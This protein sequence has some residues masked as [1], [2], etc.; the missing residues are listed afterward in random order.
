MTSVANDPD[1]SV[2]QQRA[3]VTDTVAKTSHDPVSSGKSGS[4][5]ETVASDCYNTEA[6][7]ELLTAALDDQELTALCFD[8]FPDVYDKFGDGFGRAIKV[9][10]LLDYCR[11][12]LTFDKLLRI[13]QRKNPRQY[14]RFARR[15]SQPPLDP[16][17]DTTP[18][19]YRR[20][21]IGLD[22]SLAELTPEE[23]EDVKEAIIGAMA[24][25]LRIP[26]HHIHVLGLRNGSIVVNALLPQA[27][28][29]QLEQMATH[30]QLS[31][32]D[33]GL[34]WVKPH[35]TDLRGINLRGAV[36]TAAILSE[37]DL[38]GADLR[39]AVLRDA[40]LSRTNLSDAKLYGAILE[41]AVLSE[42][43]L[44]NADL[45]GAILRD[46]ILAKANLRGADLRGAIL[47]NTALAEANMENARLDTVATSGVGGSSSNTMA[48]TS[49]ASSAYDVVDRAQDMGSTTG[50]ASATATVGGTG[51]SGTTA[52]AGST[53]PADVPA[54]EERP[55]TRPKSRGTRDAN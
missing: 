54:R 15:I 19:H 5:Q 26:R 3:P 40:V 16:P 49:T 14:E 29:E 1:R 32:K 39:G 36:L 38:S 7:R 47:Q 51:T 10:L 50:T 42:A 33:M 30:D 18:S 25:K 8:N 55:E 52:T 21:E 17:E 2:S 6:I 44:A 27:A 12:Y 4:S 22:G 35:G 34:A 46:A 43:I 45:R 37:V 48:S 13:V 24:D 41:R 11:R 53:D 9:Q 31:K 23:L 28:A 20:I